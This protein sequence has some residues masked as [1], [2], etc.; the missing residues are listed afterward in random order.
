[1]G[2]WINIVNKWNIYQ[3]IIKV[4]LSYFVYQFVI[5]CSYKKQG[6]NKSQQVER[7]WGVY[8]LKR[9]NLVRICVCSK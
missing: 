8:K 4:K 5:N 2:N 7:G 1:M 9:N 6:L 3:L